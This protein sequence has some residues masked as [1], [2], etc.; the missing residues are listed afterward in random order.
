VEQRNDT[1]LEDWMKEKTPTRRRLRRILL[2]ALIL[3]M[4]VGYLTTAFRRVEMED[5]VVPAFSLP[6]AERLLL[7]GVFSVHTERSHDAQGSREQVAAAA[8]S[9]GLDFVVIGDHPPDPR[10]PEWALWDPVFMDGVLVDGGIELRAPETGKVLAMGVDSVFKRWEGGLGL[11]TNFLA[12][13]G[14]TSMVVHGRGPRGSERWE[15]GRIRGIQGWEVLDVSEFARARLR[16]PWG[17]YH[18]LTFVVGYPFGL[19]DEALLHLMREGFETSSVAAYDSL[20]GEQALTATAGLNVH[21]KVSLGPVLL[22][23]YGPFFRTLVA[24][25]AVDD[26]LP[27]DPI[28]ARNLLGLGIRDGEVFISA[29]RTQAARGFRLRVVLD[30]GIGAPMGSNAAPLAGLTLRGGFSSDPERKVAY[31]ILRNGRETRWIQGPELE[32][33]LPRRGV[34]RVEVYTYSARIGDVFFRL[35]PWIFANPIGVL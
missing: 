18:L 28:L 12:Q 14:A 7:S 3:Y 19:A 13:Q 1:V 4:G 20:R 29:G 17:P 33:A 30:E 15:H 34:Y 11:F 23:S 21:P 22:P 10:R 27:S 26:S 25:V 35:K 16:G 32:W 5:P 8:A 24:H 2:A 31:R 9:A 6:L